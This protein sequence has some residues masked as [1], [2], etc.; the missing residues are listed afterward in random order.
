M[1]KLRQAT[2]CFLIK[3]NKVLLAMKKRGFGVGKWNGPGGKPNSGESIE[4]TAVR[5]TLEE[6]GVT[7]KSF[8]R[9]AT[10]DFFFPAD[11]AKKDWNQQVCVYLV[12][13]WEG[14]PV[15]TEEMKPAWFKYEEIPYKDMWVDD[16]YWLPQVLQGKKLKGTFSFTPDESLQDFEVIEI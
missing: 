5:E 2:S 13:D 6:I 8:D 12:T 16:I 7:I 9:V 15:E 14:E 10:L 3:D 1:G 4:E 11:L